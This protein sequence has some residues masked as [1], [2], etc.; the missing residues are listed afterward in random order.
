MTRHRKCPR[1]RPV[2]AKCVL[3]S[4]SRCLGVQAPCDGNVGHAYIVGKL[5]N[6]GVFFNRKRSSEKGN[7]ARYGRTAVDL[8]LGL[9]V[10]RGPGTRSGAA[11]GGG[12]CI[13]AKMFGVRRERGS[14]SIGQSSAFERN[15]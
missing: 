15:S 8:E 13:I 1:T 11:G 3:L 5:S 2:Q 9:A 6:R 4:L 14:G 7:R 10:E 12:S